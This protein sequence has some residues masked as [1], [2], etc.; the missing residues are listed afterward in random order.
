MQFRKLCHQGTVSVKIPIPVVSSLQELL[1]PF[2]PICEY[3]ML[4]DHELQFMLTIDE[5]LG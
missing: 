4:H 2:H 1:V 5:L 3:K